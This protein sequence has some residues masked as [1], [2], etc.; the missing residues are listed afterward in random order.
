MG[1]GGGWV[2]IDSA[3]MSKQE[4]ADGES[5]E[6]SW[7]VSHTKEAGYVTDVG[8]F[9]GSEEAIMADAPDTSR[10]FNRAVT[11]NIQNDASD[12]K[13][14][15][16]RKGSSLSCGGPFY[17]LPQGEAQLTFRTCASYVLS[18]EEA[19]DYRSFSL[20]LP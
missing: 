8:L 9:V 3:E 6:F 13:V 18:T 11:G 20:T 10:L 1:A 7:R 16:T 12:S 14:T 17:D 5:L 19:C 4:L 2:K 15:C